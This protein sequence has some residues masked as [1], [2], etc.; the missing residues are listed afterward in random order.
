MD[1]SAGQ[2]YHHHDY[3]EFLKS[4]LETAKATQSGFS[5]RGLAAQL[6]V[7]PAYVSY[8]LNGHRALTGALKEAWLP[9]LKL[10]PEEQRY[11]ELLT[12]IADSNVPEERVRAL[13]ELQR[14]REYRR[15]NRNETEVYRYMTKWYFVAIREMASLPGFKLEPAWIQK[16]LCFPLSHKEILKAIRFLKRTGFI[17]VDRKGRVQ[18][19]EKK[20]ECKGGVFKLALGQFHKQMYGLASEAIDV[21]PRDERFI[22]STTLAIPAEQLDAFKQA[23]E[24]SFERISK[25]QKSK[26]KTKRPDSVYQIGFMGFP[27]AKSPLKGE[28]D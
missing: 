8:V 15:L 21:V 19:T 27:L 10:T 2:I 7:S 18:S 13:Q 23:V 11:F 22:M 25:I 26:T 12:V 1:G 4:W 17:K 5:L 28:G 6:G 20:L 3:R 14:F 24:E 9:L 16:R